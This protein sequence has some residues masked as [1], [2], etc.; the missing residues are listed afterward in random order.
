MTEYPESE[1]AWVLPPDGTAPIH[2][3]YFVSPDQKI[4]TLYGDYNRLDPDDQNCFEVLGLVA[5]ESF[6]EWIQSL[7]AFTPG[8]SEERSSYVI[9]GRQ[10]RKVASSV[11]LEIRLVEIFKEK[12]KE[13]PED[14]EG[15]HNLSFCAGNDL[16]YWLRKQG[17]AIIDADEKAKANGTEQ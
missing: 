7:P 1:K 6:Y 16:I 9:E 8:D 3:E 4:R 5:L 13:D 2:V 12:T 15:T 10:A 14:E 11:D 17:A